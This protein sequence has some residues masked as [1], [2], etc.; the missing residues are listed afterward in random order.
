MAQN[1]NSTNIAAPQLLNDFHAELSKLLKG[2][3]L[4]RADIHRLR[5][6]LL[7]CHDDTELLLTTAHE[8]NRIMMIH[9]SGLGNNKTFHKEYTSG[10]FPLWNATRDMDVPEDLQKNLAHKLYNAKKTDNGALLLIGDRARFI[11]HDIVKRLQQDSIKFWVDF[12]DSDFK[13]LVLTHARRDGIKRLA[14]YDVATNAKANKKIIAIPNGA[15][16]AKIEAPLD[17]K[18]LYA[19]ECR[20]MRVRSSNGEMFFTLTA[21]PTEEDAARDDISYKDYLKLYFEMCDQPWDAI[22]QA[23]EHLIEMFNKASTVRFTNNDGTDISMSLV[24]KDGSHYTFCNSVIAKNVPGSEIFSAPQIDSLEGVIVAKGKFSPK[25]TGDKIIENLTMVFKKG[26]LVDFKADKGAAHFK[27]FID[28]QEGN[29]RV[30]ELGIGTN[31]HLKQHVMNTLLVE[32]IGGSFHL[33][34][35]NAYSFNEYAGK[36]VKVDNGNKSL[37]HWDITTMLIG[38]EGRIELDGVTIM[39][40]GKFL[41][42]QLKVLNEG[43]AA[44]PKSSR[45]DYW[46]H[47]TGPKL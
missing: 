29:R 28:R 10:Y 9:K 24:E 40:D 4:Y 39:K 47:Y 34:L 19:E 37:D 45:P 6:A 33:A 16:P 2:H 13:N 41:A 14:A 22:T 38:K 15:P 7:T 5:S 44:I 42:P 11:A 32:K 3:T 18:Q 8:I 43:W 26:L 23:Q 31:P 27:E 30:G 12:I 20:P 25:D 21:F 17:K 35:G 36:P 46:K 1:K